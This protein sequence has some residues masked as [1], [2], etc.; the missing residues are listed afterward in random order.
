LFLAI[1]SP[2]TMNIIPS[3]ALLL[4]SEE[5]ID[6]Y[7]AAQALASLVCNGNRGINLAIAN[8]GAVA[9]LITIIG[10]IESDMPNLMTLSEEFSLVRNP[11]QVVLDHLFEIEDVRLGSTARKSIPLLVDLLRPIPER[12]NAPPVA[13]RLSNAPPVAVRLLISIADGSDANKSLLAEA[14]AL[15]A[16]NKYLSLSPQDS[17]ETAISELLRILFCNSDLINYSD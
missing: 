1:L 8:S 7:F 6:K 16:L 15:E 2:A 12:P 5:V 11:D 14:G 10:H 13:V 4:R 17:T 9:G 3:I